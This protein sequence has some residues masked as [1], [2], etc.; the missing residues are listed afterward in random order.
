MEIRKFIDSYGDDVFAL[1]LMVTKSEDSAKRVFAKAAFDC[2]GFGETEG[3]F[4]IVRTAYSECMECENNDEA[5][6]LGIELNAKQ[7]ALLKELL[8]KPQIVR[9]IIHMHYENDLEPSQIAEVTGENE[10]Y[11]SGQL[12]KL[13]AELCASLDRSYK[14]ICLKI[15]ADDKLKSYVIRA[16]ETND[17][18]M[19]EVKSEAVPIHRWTKKQK[20]AVIIAAVIITFL[21]CIF[22]PL[23]SAYVEMQKELRD[24]EY[25]EPAT[26][27]IFS[28]T[29]EPEEEIKLQ[30]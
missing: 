12:S 8:L 14:D 21:I 17:R 11:I 19:F 28:Y 18:R 24:V 20:T 5:S 27:E 1:A 16:S 10:R 29:Y 7:D 26:D 13:S 9:A 22:I 2:E 30:D 23:W 25:E 4:P 15:C 3:I 6:T